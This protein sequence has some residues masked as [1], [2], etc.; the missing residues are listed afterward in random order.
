MLDQNLAQA[1]QRIL[2]TRELRYPLT[3]VRIRLIEAF[4]IGTKK[5]KSAYFSASDRAE[6]RKLLEAT[7]YSLDL[8]NVAGMRRDERLTVTPNEKAGS[9]RVKRDRISVKAMKGCELKVGG[10]RLR[11]PADA[12][13]DIDWTSVVGHIDH[14]CL[15]VVENYENFNRLHEITFDLP[16]FYQSPL[17]VYHGDPTESRLDYVRKFVALTQLPLLAFMDLD[18]SGLQLATKFERLEGIVAPPYE[19]IDEQLRSPISGRRDLFQAQVPMCG[20]QLNNLPPNSPAKG[21]W[22]LITRHK[23]GVVQ[24]RWIGSGVCVLWTAGTTSV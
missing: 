12:H 21:L 23:A 2:A 5:G 20:E 22:T 24:E 6:M 15:M 17:V 11:L 3:E 19:T 1:M 4:A 18:P 10:T 9:G 13:L 14:Q 16:I 8:Q 7:G